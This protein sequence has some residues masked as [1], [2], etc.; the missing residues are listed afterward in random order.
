VWRAAISKIVSFHSFLRGRGRSG[1]TANAAVLLAAQGQRVGVVEAD[2]QSPAHSFLFGL[3]RE[4]APLSLNDYLQGECP[5]E[6]TAHR[7]AEAAGLNG[8][9]W[10]VPA[11]L[12]TYEIT[13]VLREGYD[14]NRLVEGGLR[15]IE[16]LRLDTLLIDTSAGL[17]EATMA[18]IAAS[19]LVFILLRLDQR[20]YQGTGVMV[21]VARR[22]E[23]PHIRLIANQALETFDPAEVKTR[24]QAAHHAEV[25]AVIPHSTDVLALASNG[26]FALRYPEHPVTAACRHIAAHITASPDVR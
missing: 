14:V 19:D 2:L 18:V 8:Q 13:R 12:D 17:N 5:I 21:E 11:S 9:V 26:V 15:L 3:N 10:L 4:A 23:T 16:S 1:L 25:A 20:D 6:Q 7:V 22:L 24:V